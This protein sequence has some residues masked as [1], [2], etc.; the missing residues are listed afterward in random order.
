M[1]SLVNAIAVFASG[2]VFPVFSQLL[3]NVVS[4]FYSFDAHIIREKA[5]F[6]SGMFAVL[7]VGK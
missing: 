5:Y 2:V 1:L 3:S 7:A 6:W 4:Y